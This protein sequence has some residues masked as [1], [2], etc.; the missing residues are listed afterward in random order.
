VSGANEV[1]KFNYNTLAASPDLIA[2][3]SSNAWPAGMTLGS[4]GTTGLTQPSGGAFSD[5][6]Y[7]FRNAGTGGNGE[8]VIALAGNGTAS[9]Y[10]TYHNA[11]I[12]ASSW[13]FETHIYL[14]NKATY[15]SGMVMKLYGSA[16]VSGITIKQQSG[17]ATAYRMTIDFEASGSSGSGTGPTINLTDL[18][19]GSWKH[20]VVSADRTSAGNYTFY[21]FVDGV[22]QNAGGTAYNFISAGV[23]AT[24]GLW[25]ST[26]FGSRLGKFDFIGSAPRM[27]Y[28][29]DNTRLIIGN[30]FNTA[31]F[32]APTSAFTA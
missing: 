15:D 31:G 23:G 21:I 2:E 20:L 4:N 28:S 10:A 29:L 19:G 32:T 9:N 12:P 24:A 22:L 6:G 1:F 13:A 18:T 27:A 14:E 16:S 3:V 5:G 11:N 26:T 30:P 17:S 8:G 25:S 7:Y